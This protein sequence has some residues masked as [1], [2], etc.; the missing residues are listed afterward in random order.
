[1]K[2]KRRK[3]NVSVFFRV[4]RTHVFALRRYQKSANSFNRVPPFL[5]FQYYCRNLCYIR[6]FFLSS[7]R[8][9]TYNTTYQLV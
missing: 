9:G 5:L 7:V 2:N 4:A 6:I 3:E 1:M 8:F